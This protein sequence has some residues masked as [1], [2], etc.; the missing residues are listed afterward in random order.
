MG[1]RY[2]EP[3]PEELVADTPIRSN[4]DGEHIYVLLIS[5]DKSRFK[6]LKEVQ[7]IRD[8]E[9][10]NTQER[11]DLP[12]W[13][14]WCPHGGSLVVDEPQD[15]PEQSTRSDCGRENCWIVF[16]GPKR[17]GRAAEAKIV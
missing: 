11:P 17:D 5:G 9:H 12:W 7:E 2:E 3:D 16:Y 13:T 6:V 14:V 4:T 1:S 10:R 8:Y 15:F